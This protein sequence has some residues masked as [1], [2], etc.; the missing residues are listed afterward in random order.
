MS[1][2]DEPNGR[3]PRERED[4][5]RERALDE[6]L[7]EGASSEL[8]RLRRRPSLSGAVLARLDEDEAPEERAPRVRARPILIAAAL[9]ASVLAAWAVFRFIALAREP[10]PQPI[11]VDESAPNVE[12]AS[13]PRTHAPFARVSFNAV[14]AAVER[15][16]EPARALQAEVASWGRESRAAARF[17]L[18]RV[19]LGPIEARE[20]NSGS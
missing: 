1:L 19:R 16:V 9:A 12:G 4:G 11:A 8:R 2:H 7:R 18:S 3:A 5:P 17:L 6:L 10:A 14:P 15:G 13:S 20:T